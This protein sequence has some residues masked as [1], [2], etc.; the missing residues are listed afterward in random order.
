VLEALHFVKLEVGS[1]NI[2]AGQLRHQLPMKETRLVGEVFPLSR[3]GQAMDSL[4]SRDLILVHLGIEEPPESEIDLPFF[5]AKAGFE[6]G[7]D[8]RE[9][10]STAEIALDPFPIRRAGVASI[11][12]ETMSNR[13]LLGPLMG[14]PRA[15][16][17]F[18]SSLGVVQN[19]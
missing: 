9:P 16:N 17:P 4:I 7:V 5:L 14:V 15:T 19:G 1:A 6:T 13:T 18:K 8:E 10:T 3:D 2:Q 11:S 12:D